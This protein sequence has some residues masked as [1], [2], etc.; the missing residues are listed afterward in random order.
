MSRKFK[1]ANYEE[2]LNQTIRL[3]DALP[4]DHLARFVVEIVSHLDLGRIY[5]QYAS[6][7]GEAFAPEILLGLLFY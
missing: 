3:G 2:T 1:T 5:G 6:V 4:P 7:G